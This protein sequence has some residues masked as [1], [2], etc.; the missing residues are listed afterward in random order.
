MQPTKIVEIP[1][2]LIQNKAEME[3]EKDIWDV[4]NLGV[5]VNQS[6]ADYKLNFSKISQ[7]WLRGAAKRFV[8]YYLSIQSYSQCCNK[9]LAVKTFSSF[10]EEVCPAKQPE[11]INRSLIVEYLNFL[12]NQ[13]LSAQTRKMYIIGLRQFTNLCIREGWLNL[14]EK[15]IIYDDDLPK[16][17][18]S[19]PKYIPQEILLQLNQYLDELPSYISRL[20]LVLQGTGRRVSEICT[21][22]FNPLLQDVQGDWFLK[23]FQSKM[24]KED[25]IPVSREV[26]AVI[27]EQQRCVNQDYGEDCLYLFPQPIELCKGSGKQRYGKPIY[28][29]RVNTYLN[30]LAQEKKIKD[31]S[32]KIWSFQSH[33][34]RH[35]VGT[36]MI[37]NGVPI[38]IVKRFLGQENLEMTMRYAHVHDQTLKEEFSKFQGKVVDV[39]E[40]VEPVNPEIDAAELQWFKKNIQAQALPNGSC[41]PTVMQGCP[42]AN[43]C[44]TCTHFRTNI[45]FLEQHK[46]ELE[47][48]KKIIEKAKT[49]GWTRQVE[50]NERVANNLQNII[51][52]LEIDNG[53]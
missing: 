43:A 44:L 16:P 47:Q 29:K 28:Q 37:N 1:M 31:S 9:L 13:K 48:T 24:N 15:Q 8:R 2:V 45:E 36:S 26:V 18:E 52:S 40:A 19:L 21:L 23:H 11:Q 12:L 50:M 51:A 25:T 3:Y 4:R 22:P 41:V 34:F 5:K 53:K 6:R 49:N 14:T 27:Q 33:Q 20:V 35:T 38:H 30:R 17:V 46:K 32:G 10:I 42:H 7:H 39:S